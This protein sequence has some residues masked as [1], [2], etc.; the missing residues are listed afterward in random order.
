MPIYLAHGFRWPRDGYTGIRVHTIIN[1]LDGVSTEYI[2]NANSRTALLESLRTLHPTILQPLESSGR[3][4]DFL[5]QYDPA[6]VS[7]DAVIQPFAFVC[8]W[9]VMIAGGENAERYAL[10]LRQSEVLRPLSPQVSKAK[11]KERVRT[12]PMSIAPPFNSPVTITNLSVN[13]EEVMADSPPL[14]T[15]AWT[16]LAELRDKLA[17][18]EKIGWWVV[19]NGDPDRSFPGDEEEEEDDDYDDEEEETGVEKHVEGG[20]KAPLEKTTAST[21]PVVTSSTAGRMPPPMAPSPT[22]TLPASAFKPLPLR[23]KE[24]VQVPAKDPKAPSLRKKF[25]GKKS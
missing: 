10:N 9:V 19:Y 13:M 11:A 25:F 3:A 12:K 7:P 15:E 18:G 21:P 23:P 1:N 4:L 22:T 6:D 16:A 2:Q 5:E 24:A 14:T 20:G 8:D 17:E